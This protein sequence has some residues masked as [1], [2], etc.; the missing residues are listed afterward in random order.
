MSNA[1]T[2]LRRTLFGVLAL[3]CLALAPPAA[4]AAAPAA[5]PS[6]VADQAGVSA[7]DID[8]LVST[9]QDDQKRQQLIKQLQALSAAEKGTQPAVP[10]TPSDLLSVVTDHLQSIGSDM[11]DA[12]SVLVAAPSLMGWFSRQINDPAIL[13]G[14]EEVG[15]NIGLILAAAILADFVVRQLVRAIH[16]R[17]TRRVPTSWF[18]RIGLLVLAVLLA[19]LPF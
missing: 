15:R 1:P 4:A 10:P 11:V 8:R 3:L 6:Q 5:T 13:A 17:A 16:R 19:A 12:T 2:L 7:V 18:G 9:L 14:W